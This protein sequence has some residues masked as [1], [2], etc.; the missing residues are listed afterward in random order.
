MALTVVLWLG[1]AVCSVPAA[2]FCLQVFT[3]WLRPEFLH[4]YEQVV[5]DPGSLPQTVILVPAHNEEKVIADTLGA[6]KELAHAVQVLVVADNCTDETARIACSMGA[7]VVERT[8]ASLRGKG[9]A[10]QYGLDQLKASPPAVVIV[11]DA[12][13]T[14]TAADM[15]RLALACTRESCPVQGIYLMQAPTLGAI[16]SKVAEFAWLVKALVRPL[17]WRSWGGTSQ[18]MGSGFA[19]PWHIAG[20]LNLA[21]GHIVEDMKLTVDLATRRQAPRFVTDAKVISTFPSVDSAQVTQR[22]RWE[23]GHLSMVLSEVPQAMVRAIATLNGQLLAVALDLL[24]PPLSLLVLALGSLTVLA[25]VQAVVWEGSLPGLLLACMAVTL[26]VAV[27]LAWSRWG[28]S[29]LSG[30][31]LLSIPMFIWGKLAVYA[32]FITRRERTWTRTDRD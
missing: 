1:L 31:E 28:R 14:T 9:Y 2:V 6:L 19:L 8:S 24:V 32:G 22:R 30:R 4:V 29:V 12:D 13:C 21:S 16:G 10:L 27:L 18:L 17:G 5:P 7:R 26:A 3:A 25:L 15:H 11:L 23:H 20:T